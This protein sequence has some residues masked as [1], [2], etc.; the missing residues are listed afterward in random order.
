MGQLWA[1]LAAMSRKCRNNMREPTGNWEKA[2]QE[3][4]MAIVQMMS[5]QGADLRHAWEIARNRQDRS[6]AIYAITRM[7]KTELKMEEV[8]AAVK[9]LQRLE[10]KEEVTNREDQEEKLKKWIEKVCK[11]SNLKDVHRWTNSLN[12]TSTEIEKSGAKEPKEI[13]RRVRGDW[14]KQWET[15]NE[16]KLGK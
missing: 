3:H 16:I 5:P 11:S 4:Q 12:K 6:A 13:A 15:E 8:E 7:L 14:S 9:T 10:D 1:T 2:I